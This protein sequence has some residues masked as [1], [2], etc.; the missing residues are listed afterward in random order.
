MDL[1]MPDMSGQELARRLVVNASECQRGYLLQLH[2]TPSISAFP[3]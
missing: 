2:R 1:V 3:W